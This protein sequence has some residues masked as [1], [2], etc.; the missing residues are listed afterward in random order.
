MPD[1]MIPFFSAVQIPNQ[2]VDADRTNGLGPQGAIAVG[3]NTPADG[4]PGFL[5]TLRAGLRLSTSSKPDEAPARQTGQF[6]PDKLLKNTGGHPQEAADSWGAS[7]VLATGVP[8]DA[9]QT[10]APIF[11]GMIESAPAEPAPEELQPAST[12]RDQPVPVSPEADVRAAV[13]GVIARRHADGVQ[14]GRDLLTDYPDVETTVFISD[15]GKSDGELAVTLKE[16][17]RDSA[18]PAA[19]AT[20]AGAEQPNSEGWEA[21]AQFDAPSQAGAIAPVTRG[22]P[23]ASPEA[24][25]LPG[26]PEPVARKDTPLDAPVLANARVDAERQ[27]GVATPQ[28]AKAKAETPDSTSPVAT[29][30]AWVETL[31]EAPNPEP[32]D[33]FGATP[34]EVTDRPGVSE[35]LPRVAHQTRSSVDQLDP[36]VA[37]SAADRPDQDPLAAATPAPEVS[38]PAEPAQQ[39]TVAVQ[40]I[41]ET[42]APATGGQ[43]PPRQVDLVFGAL[44]QQSRDL[45]QSQPTIQ[46]LGVAQAGT[47]QAEAAKAWQGLAPVA[48]EVSPGKLPE[49]GR[50]VPGDLKVELR[51]WSGDP[52]P[53][54]ARSRPQ[55]PGITGPIAPGAASPMPVPPSNV[56]VAAEIGI[57][58]MEK[59]TAPLR[60]QETKTTT[61]APLAPATVQGQSPVI[62]APPPLD[63]E[64][65][66]SGMRMDGEAAQTGTATPAAGTV[67]VSTSNSAQ[68]TQAPSAAATLVVPENLPGDLVLPPEGDG[69]ITTERVARTGEQAS[70]ATTGT[71]TAAI[72]ASIAASIQAN[73]PKVSGDTTEILLDPEELGRVRMTLSGSETAGVVILQVERPETLELMRR[74]I[75]QMKAELAEAGWEN[76]D[77]SFGQEGASGEGA[78]P[79]PGMSHAPE[80]ESAM[81]TNMLAAADSPGT[82]TKTGLTGLDLRL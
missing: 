65:S 71:R 15:V 27:D 14:D 76:V 66:P 41:P 48:T 50:V 43:P 69:E 60:P 23:N 9:P 46:T 1:P 13:E 72:P 34:E 4:Q 70:T 53:A 2:S 30:D 5:E 22:E 12:D 51:H 28:L 8:L 24:D 17:R 45:L 19:P 16:G 47:A 77:F 26:T 49:A 37:E 44:W 59:P 58:T 11:P 73:L 31:K 39:S 57:G 18:P 55:A 36:A 78:Q 7:Q 54:P 74:N 21:R 40:A 67:R 20:G 61:S 79:E 10:G 63:A 64:A 80:Q 62:Q 33:G 29:R 75:E 38:K 6:E 68:A 32:R 82:A 42:R 3:Q 35:M 25:V 81:N 52:M 56:P